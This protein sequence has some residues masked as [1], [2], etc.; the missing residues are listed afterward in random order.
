MHRAP[1]PLMRCRGDRPIAVNAAW[2][3]LTGWSA[4]ELT[5]ES[6]GQRV[7]PDHQPALRELLALERDHLEVPFLEADGGHRWLELTVQADGDEVVIAAFDI[8]RYKQLEDVGRQQATHLKLAQRAGR[9]VTWEWD[10]VRDEISV[11]G[12]TRRLQE[13]SGFRGRPTRQAIL[14]FVHPSDQGRLQQALQ[15]CLQS[16]QP[17]SLE[18][19]MRGANGVFGPI[20]LR[21]KAVEEGRR[22]VGVATD[23][24]EQRRTERELRQERERAEVTLNSIGD[25]V[26]RTDADGRIDYLNAAGELLLARDHERLEGR[27]FDEVVRLLADDS[28]QPLRSP[29]DHCLRAEGAWRATL[30]SPRLGE[31]DVSL[32]AAALHHGGER[33]GGVVVARDLTEAETAARHASFLATHDELT[34]LTH[35]GEFESRL[36]R[37]I[38]EAAA[39]SPEEPLALCHL[40]L[41][42]L[43]LI[44]E[45]HGHAAGDA[46]LAQFASFLKCRFGGPRVLGRLG[47]DE[48]GLLLRDTSP[49][50]ARQAIESLVD[51]LRGLRFTADS[52]AVS[53]RASIGLV[54]VSLRGGAQQ[55]L[56]TARAA[57]DLARRQGGD[58][59]KE[60][61]PD[62]GEIS[63]RWD[64]VD[65]VRALH[66]ALSG[67]GFRLFAQPLRTCAGSDTADRLELLLRMDGENGE[68]ILPEEFMPLAE[69]HRFA[70]EIDRWV[71]ARALEQLAE[72]PSLRLAI[73]LSR[74]SIADEA[75]VRELMTALESQRVDPNR[76]W[77]EITEAADSEETRRR[78]HA[79]RSRGCRFVL[80]DFGS[81]RSSFATLRDLPVDFLKIDGHLVRGICHDPTQLAL[82]EAINQ[83]GHVMQLKTIAEGVEDEA[84]FTALRRMRVDFAQGFWVAPPHPLE[85]RGNRVTTP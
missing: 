36:L 76:L 50:A 79:L 18:V 25:G 77:L 64:N 39:S 74:Q 11:P 10:V 29:L 67:D 16:G 8:A 45:V 69:R 17:L 21:G 75:F 47:G 24:A 83:V 78:M 34:S 20:L 85:L 80:D 32:S 58:R 44:N 46:V 37:A 4:D 19:R 61:R 54:A 28:S 33:R 56:E 27:P 23:I 38:D 60:Y 35:R 12:N 82:V 5:G 43:G 2:E 13:L 81:G 57:C 26:I 70:R 49:P 41:D 55:A 52:K 84:T 65:R 53:V 51:E 7:R 14:P 48:F 71:L 72:S 66:A 22:V 15:Q 73:N 42:D 62:D 63:A 6:L 40:D 9:S 30:L 31:R 1:V 68:L 59:V 3:R